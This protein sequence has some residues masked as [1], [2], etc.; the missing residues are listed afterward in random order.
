MDDL[1]SMLLDLEKAGLT[2]YRVTLLL[3]QEIPKL[4]HAT[5]HRLYHSQCE[6][7]YRLGKAIERLHAQTMKGKRR[8]ST[9]TIREVSDAR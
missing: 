5:M 9:D 2:R 7:S 8:R 4:G 1:K 3:R 6:P